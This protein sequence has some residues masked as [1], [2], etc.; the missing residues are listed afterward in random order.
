[1]V[2]L[3]VGLVVV[4]VVDVEVAGV[5]V[6]DVGVVVELVDPPEKRGVWYSAQVSR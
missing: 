6:A 2:V 3:T 1:V 4:G 5:E